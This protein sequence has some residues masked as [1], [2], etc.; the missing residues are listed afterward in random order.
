MDDSPTLDPSELAAYEREVPTAPIK[1]LTWSI[2][3]Y[4]VA[5]LLALSRMTHAQIAEHTLVPISAITR[6]K[7]HPD[8]RKYMEDVVLES[9]ET[10]KARSLMLLSKVLDARVE[11]AE[12][13]GSYTNLTSKDTIDILAEMRKQTE[14]DKDEEKSKYVQ[15][16]EAL[17]KKT[18]ANKLSHS[19]PAG[20][21]SARGK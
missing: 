10:L 1:P 8:F 5:Q 9:A 15:I 7:Q 21:L 4:E 6:W 14:G 2:E 13:G 3:K 20:L 18:T 12:Q 17:L 19:S 16:V 11:A